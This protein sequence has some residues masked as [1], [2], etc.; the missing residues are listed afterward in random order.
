MAALPT[1][2][3]VWT[4]M[5]TT[6]PAVGPSYIWASTNNGVLYQAGN[7]RPVFVASGAVPVG[8]TV[9]WTAAPPSVPN[10]APTLAWTSIGATAALYFGA[11][12]LTYAA[13]A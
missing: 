8:T 3:L 10:A 7:A 1:F 11:D 4:T 5:V 6:N 13:G 9:T 2:P 12:G